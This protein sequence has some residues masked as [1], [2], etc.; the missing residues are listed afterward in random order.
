MNKKSYTSYKKSKY[1]SIKHSTYFD[2]YDHL[3]KKYI[4]LPITFVEVG[5]LNGGSLFMWRD[6][7]GEQARIIGIDLNVN[8]KKWE[9]YGFE[10]YIGDQSQPNF[11]REIKEK[12][13]NIDVLLDDGGH[14]FEQQ[15]ITTECMLESLNNDGIIIVEDTHTS[16]MD[17]YGCRKYSFIEYIK[18]MIDEINAR[19]G[20]LNKLKMEKRVWSLEIFESI[21]AI[22]INR[23]LSIESKPETNEGETFF[24]VDYRYEN[25]NKNIKKIINYLMKKSKILRKIIIFTHDNLYDRFIKRN[26]YY[27]NNLNK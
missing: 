6:F 22:K 12:I 16:Y 14:T 18:N 2:V 5:V 11:W 3:L 13:G 26:G 19:F 4:G 27:R 7:L 25:H 15:I 21:V 8:A 9:N 1:L 23:N 20:G 17:G 24:E 10:I